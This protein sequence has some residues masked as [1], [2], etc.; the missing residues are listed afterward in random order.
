M[1][2]LQPI[3]SGESGAGKTENTKKVI[4]YFANVGASTK[5]DEKKD[6]KVHTIS[7]S[8]LNCPPFSFAFYLLCPLFSSSAS[9]FNVNVCILLFPRIRR[10][11]PFLQFHFSFS[12]SRVCVI[13]H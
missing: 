13:D 1:S 11:I 6:K 8:T 10:I 12:L 5:K 7:F 3:P 2:T 9:L 4:A